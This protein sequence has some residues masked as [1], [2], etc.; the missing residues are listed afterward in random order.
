MLRIS[1]IQ[2]GNL[3]NKDF[4]QRFSWSEEDIIQYAFNCSKL[5]VETHEQGVKHVETSL[6]SF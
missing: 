6:V 4:D 1:I 2:G 5:T 3:L